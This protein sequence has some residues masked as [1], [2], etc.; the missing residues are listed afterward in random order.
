MSRYNEQMELSILLDRKSFFENQ[1]I[2]IRDNPLDYHHNEIS[3]T[4]SMLN[5]IDKRLM[6][7]RHEKALRRVLKPTTR[8]T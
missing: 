7:M 3:N 2:K 6:Q 4:M 8:K 1:W 5:K